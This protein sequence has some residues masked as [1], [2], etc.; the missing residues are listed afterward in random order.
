MKWHPNL[1]SA[2]REALEVYNRS[3]VNP[4]VLLRRMVKEHFRWGSRDRRLIRSALYDI[5]RHWRFYSSMADAF[6]DT[7]FATAVL[8]AY[9]CHKE[10]EP[11][12]F[13]SEIPACPP[14]PAWQPHHSYPD[15][16]IESVVE[17]F[18]RDEAEGIL[19][20]L[21][22]A[23]L[24]VIR[25]N[26]LK[27]S[28]EEFKRKLKEKKYLFRNISGLPEAVVFDRLYRLTKTRWYREGLFEIQDVSSQLA[29][30]FIDALPGQ[31]V[32]DAC[33]GAGGKTLQLAAMMQN[34]G[35][36]YA[37]D[38]DSKKLQILKERA[39]RAGVRNIR[40]VSVVSGEILKKMRSKADIVVT[41][42]PCSGSGT[43]RRKPHLKWKFQMEDWQRVIAVQRQIIDDYSNMVRPGGYLIY[44]T[45]SILSREN[46]RQVKDFLERH[47]NFTF[48][49]EQKLYPPAYDFDGFYMAKL[50]RET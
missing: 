1:F 35:S 27:I 28:P 25:I 6:K 15:W 21:N 5:I 39:R 16:F 26:T 11:P 32:V 36:L 8:I 48:V 9:S 19:E 20:K 42:V 12:A 37:L 33:A 10:M 13:L 49:S 47:K 31:T 46:D 38:V 44:I 41:D 45:C 4:E 50:K 22:Q 3:G 24:P 23:S 2:L 29:G 30:K 17:D 14:L 34:N 40:K 18:G 43:Y 7:D